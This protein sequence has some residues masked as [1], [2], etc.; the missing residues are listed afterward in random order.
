[1]ANRRPARQLSIRIL[2]AAS[3]ARRE[4]VMS[5]HSYPHLRSSRDQSIAR[6]LIVIAMGVFVLTA[7]L[8]L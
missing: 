7:A 5:G 2:P 3:S 4:A 8:A 1:M 6:W